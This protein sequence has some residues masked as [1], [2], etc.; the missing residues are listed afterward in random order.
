MLQAR[1]PT[2]YH[3]QYRRRHASSRRTLVVPGAP[4]DRIEVNRRQTAGCGKLPA[5]VL[6][7][8]AILTC[9]LADTLPSREAKHVQLGADTVRKLPRQAHNRKSDSGPL[10][11]LGRKVRGGTL[12]RLSCA[13][14]VL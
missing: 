1:P 8:P 4:V 14:S 11:G 7:D 2:R 9:Q 12:P 5:G 6:I 10:V 3:S 13:R